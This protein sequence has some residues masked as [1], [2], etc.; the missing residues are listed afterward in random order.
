[1]STNRDSFNRI[2]KATPEK[3]YR[4]FIEP[5]AL[6]FWTPPYGFL[7]VV[8]HLDAKING[9]FSMT[10]TNFTTGFEHSFG[11]KYIQLLPNEYLKYSDVFDDSNLTG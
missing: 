7:C 8:H 2:I 5:N 4:A 11:G 1:M 9:T 6:S 3:V 10:F